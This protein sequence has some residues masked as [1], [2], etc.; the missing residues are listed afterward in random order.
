MNPDSHIVLYAKHYYKIGDVMDDLKVLVS[1]RSGVAK[2]HISDWDVFLT[3]FNIAYP[4]MRDENH[5]TEIIRHTFNYRNATTL[6][7]LIE[8]FLFTVIQL[9]QVK[10]DSGKILYKLDKP[11]YSFLPKRKDK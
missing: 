7:K 9:I 4:F 1:H 11:D 5:W 10:D 8:C 6:K 3:V 2:K